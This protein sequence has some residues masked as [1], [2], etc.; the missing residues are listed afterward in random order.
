[1]RDHNSDELKQ[2]RQSEVQVRISGQFARIK[3]N[4]VVYKSIG[5]P[6]EKCYH[7]QQKQPFRFEEQFKRIEHTQLV[8]N[9]IKTI[10]TSINN[11]YFAIWLFDPITF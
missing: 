3:A 5:Q 1:M 4:T 10:K 8:Y 2:N 6:V 9:Y 11:D 7:R